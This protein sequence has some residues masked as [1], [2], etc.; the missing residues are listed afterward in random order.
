M[1]RAALSKKQEAE[2]RAGDK[3]QDGARLR[4]AMRKTQRGCE[5]D[6]KKLSED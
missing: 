5:C 1:L 2:H 3:K 4:Q 6:F